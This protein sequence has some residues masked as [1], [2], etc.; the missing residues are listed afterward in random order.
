[1]SVGRDDIGLT[2]NGVTLAA[3]APVDAILGAY[4]IAAFDDC[5]GHINPVAGYHYHGHSDDT[6]GYHYHAASVAE[7]MFIEC[8][9]G[10]TA[11]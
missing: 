4:T 3:P 8:F 9:S 7:N 6:R 5:A 10:A 11:R 1:M 2:L